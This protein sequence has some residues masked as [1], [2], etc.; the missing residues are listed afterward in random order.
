[1]EQVSIIRMPSGGASTPSLT[2]HD[3]CHE[4]A[5]RTLAMDMSL[6]MIGNLLART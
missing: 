2:L 5:P 4:H 1:M 6:T 3:L